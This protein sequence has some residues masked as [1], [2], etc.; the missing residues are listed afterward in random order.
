MS[1]GLSVVMAGL[2]MCEACVDLYMASP[3]GYD[4]IGATDRRLSIANFKRLLINGT[5]K[6]ICGYR[7]GKLVAFLLARIGAV[8]LHSKA[9]GISQEYYVTNMTGF[10]AARVLKMTH[11]L[12]CKIGENAGVEVATSHCSHLDNEQVLCKILAKAGWEQCGYVVYRRLGQGARQRPQTVATA[13]RT[14][15]L[16]PAPT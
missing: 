14:P 12:M 2:S 5:H 3:Y 8:N 15:R 16:G 10:S 6:L 11:E 9:V 7:D 1:A 4:P 13:A